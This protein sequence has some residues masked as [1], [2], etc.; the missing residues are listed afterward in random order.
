MAAS[1][2]GFPAELFKFLK[3][4]KENNNREWFNDNKP[5]YKEYIVEPVCDF[6][7]VLRPRLEKISKYYVADSRAHGGSMFRIYRDTRF[8]RDK[9]PYK[10]HV[11]CQFRHVAGKDAHAPGFYIHIEPGNIR[12]GGGVWRPPNPVL[13]QIRSRI[14][15]KPDAWKKIISNP[16]FRKRFV[17]VDGEQLQRPPKGFT[18]DDPYLEDLKRK[19]FFIMQQ[20][21]DNTLL[22]PGIVSEVERVFKSASPLMEF[23]TLA[24]ELPYHKR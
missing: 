11:G 3:L 18:K 23:L 6:I 9:R 13:Q 2:P 20:H 5:Q 15:E 4:L 14:V 16:T 19:S 17:S 1:F 7:S 10:E 24:V 21:E 12:I 22:Q 8:A